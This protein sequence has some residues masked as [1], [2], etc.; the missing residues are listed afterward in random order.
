[1]HS[2]DRGGGVISPSFSSSPEDPD[3]V[4]VSSLCSFAPLQCSGLAFFLF[5][6]ASSR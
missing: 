6:S 4:G 5:V 3:S 1:M 2:E